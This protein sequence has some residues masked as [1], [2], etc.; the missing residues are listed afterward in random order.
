MRNGINLDGFLHVLGV[1]YVPYVLSAL[2]V[3]NHKSRAFT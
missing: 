1:F 2:S 3:N